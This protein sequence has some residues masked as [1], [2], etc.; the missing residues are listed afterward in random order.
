MV[1]SSANCGGAIAISRDRNLLTATEGL[2][3][4]R[5]EEEEMIVSLKQQGTS[6]TSYFITV[7]VEWILEPL[8]P[9]RQ[10]PN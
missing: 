4:C 2:I 3:H 7:H 6:N 1:A 8:S 9:D 10:T 5:E